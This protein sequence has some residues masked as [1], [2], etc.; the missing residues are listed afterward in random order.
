MGVLGWTKTE[1]GSHACDEHGRRSEA[2]VGAL[3]LASRC[4]ASKLLAPRRSIEAL[5]G[6]TSSMGTKPDSQLV[7]SGSDSPSL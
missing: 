5:F 4:I 2:S 6:V 7:S 1:R 3:I